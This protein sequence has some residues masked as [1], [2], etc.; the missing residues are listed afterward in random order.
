MKALTLTLAMLLTTAASALAAGPL[1]LNFAHLESRADEV[2][3]VTLDGKMLQMASG[4]LSTNEPDEAKVKNVVNGLKGIYVRS[5]EF[6][7]DNAWSAADVD[8]VRKQLTSDWQR[9][10]NVRSKTAENVEI[11]LSGAKDDPGL[12]IISAEPREFTVVQ[13]VGPIDLDQ[14]S[15]LDGQFGIPKMDVEKKK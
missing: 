9:I 8:S 14:L 3:E 13:I 2:V 4:F 1:K 11:Y 15:E 7:S 12:V 6:S 5:F 10:V